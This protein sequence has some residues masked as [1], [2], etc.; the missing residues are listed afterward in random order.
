M[1]L[2]VLFK[3]PDTEP[4]CLPWKKVHGPVELGRQL[5]A[6]PN[7]K[8]LPLVRITDWKPPLV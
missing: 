1:K 4:L 2:A 6:K 8:Q 3:L 7:L 5:I